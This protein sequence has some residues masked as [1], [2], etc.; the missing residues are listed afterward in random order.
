MI[1]NLINAITRCL[2]GFKA[3]RQK[4]SDRSEDDKSKMIEETQSKININLYKLIFKTNV[5]NKIKMLLRTRQQ[6][7][8]YIIKR[9]YWT[10]TYGQNSNSDKPYNYIDYEKDVSNYN[11]EVKD[12]H[13]YYKQLNH[14][15]AEQK[16][17]L[18]RIQHNL[19]ELNQI[20]NDQKYWIFHS[21]SLSYI[22]LF[23]YIFKM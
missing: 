17:E 5:L 19:S 10:P 2:N 11:K 4:R 21:V 15:N 9:P 13:L 14:I 1:H 22:G 3:K 8:N 7:K 20:I 6:L 18:I 23:A 16:Q 12:I